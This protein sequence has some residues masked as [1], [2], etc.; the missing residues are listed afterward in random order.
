M[1]LYTNILWYSNIYFVVYIAL[2]N[3]IK[4]PTTIPKILSAIKKSVI[5]TIMKMGMYLNPSFASPFCIV[6]IIIEEKNEVIIRLTIANILKSSYFI[7][8]L[9]KESANPA[10]DAALDESPKVDPRLVITFINTPESAKSTG[11]AAI[12]ANEMNIT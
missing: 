1:F 3:H 5:V 6:A 12:V 10:V 4:V 9:E 11:A 2:R 7:P 8:A